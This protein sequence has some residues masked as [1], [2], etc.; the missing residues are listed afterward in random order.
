MMGI[1]TIQSFLQ[2]FLQDVVKHFY[3][4]N[5]KV[6]A[7]AESAVSLFVVPL[8][9]GGTA[10]TLVAGIASDK[11]GKRKPLMYAAIVIC[12][13]VAV[14]FWL[15]TRVS[16]MSNFN[17][18]MCCALL[19]GIGFGMYNSLNWAIDTD[20]LPNKKDKEVQQGESFGKDMAIWSASIVLPQVVAT[21]VAG[22]I[23]DWCNAKLRFNYGYTIIFSMSI[24]NLILSLIA[25]AFVK[26][27]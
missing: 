14:D 16:F 23:L 12:L 7:N 21:P 8:L 1:Y 27:K 17:L 10:S 3:L 2:Y 6:A 9:I 20:V 24:G 5:I 25:F 22:F 18:I 4:F 11:M 13:C 15:A 26:I 19:F